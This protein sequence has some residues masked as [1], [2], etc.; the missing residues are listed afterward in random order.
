MNQP[1]LFPSLKFVLT[2]IPRLNFV[3]PSNLWAKLFNLTHSSLVNRSKPKITPKRT[4]RTYFTTMSM[5]TM[6]QET[7]VGAKLKGMQVKTRKE[8][9]EEN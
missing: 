1:F 4:K 5:E 7:T 3:S 8:E 9:E 2:L 6:E